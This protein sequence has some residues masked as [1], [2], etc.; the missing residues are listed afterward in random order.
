MLCCVVLC[1]VMLYYV[2]L[3]FA[4]VG[5]VMLC[6]IARYLT[7]VL[8]DTYTLFK[9]SLNNYFILVYVKT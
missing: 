8:K 4:M 9:Q 7:I 6:L 2:M 3:W 5:Y 1:C